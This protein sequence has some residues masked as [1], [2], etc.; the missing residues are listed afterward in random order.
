MSQ[1]Q[2]P[3]L[4]TRTKRDEMTFG[5]LPDFVP[6][7]LVG[8]MKGDARLYTNN[9]V[10]DLMM[11]M[12]AG[13]AGMRRSTVDKLENLRQLILY[14]L[15]GK[16]VGDTAYW[17][18]YQ[19][20]A[21]A[22]AQLKDGFS[23][24]FGGHLERL[25]LASHYVAG[26][27]E[28]QLLEV[29]EVPSSFYTTLTSGVR[30]LSEEVRFTAPENKPRPMTKEEQLHVL[31]MGIGLHAGLTHEVVAELTPELAK[32]AMIATDTFILRRD[33][34]NP[35]VGT[36]FTVEATDLGQVFEAITGKP[37]ISPETAA[38]LDSNIVPCGFI[39]DRD[40]DKK[41]FVGNT[42]LG[43]IA[44]F[45]VRED[46][47]FKVMEEKYTTIGWKT[48]AEVIEMVGRCEAWTQY[49]S[50][51]FEGLEKVLREQCFTTQPERPALA[52]QAQ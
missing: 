44:V 9:E 36:F 23:I 20:A 29:P 3:K 4:Y 1:A 7:D 27:H 48:S 18:M 2:L 21:G 22:E 32:D 43:V 49:L 30:E 38:A 42:H 40:M 37:P 24:G 6:N 15:A 41:G 10:H 52:E 39:S 50:E 13:F 35:Q 28:G 14:T 47:D 8:N 11:D 16:I 51:H 26:E 17:A 45:R 5:I 33:T 19:R 31:G 34:M 12:D 46:M 25:D